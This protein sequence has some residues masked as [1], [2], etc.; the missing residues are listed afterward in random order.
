MYFLIGSKLR[1]HRRNAF[2]SLQPNGRKQKLNVNARSMTVRNLLSKTKPAARW[3]RT[4]LWALL[5]LGWALAGPPADA[6]PGPVTHRAARTRARPLPPDRTTA[7]P[8]R[9]ADAARLRELAAQREFQYVEAD[10]NPDAWGAFWARVRRWLGRHLGSPAGRA[11]W[12]Y[13]AYAAVLGALVF[14]VLKLLQVDITGTFGR[15]PRRGLAYDTAA[16]NIHEVDFAARI[17]E[18][19]AAGNLRLATRLGYLEVLKRLTDH[20][21]IKWQPDKT[22]HAYLAELAA[23]PLREAF[24]GATREFEYVWYGELPLSPALYEQARAGQRAATAPL[25]GNR[26]AAASPP[27]SATAQPA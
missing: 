9:R 5:L 20:G 23:G 7:L 6:Q 12:K 27:V 17:A 8:P 19:E 10:A 21:L 4:A 11:A 3:R 25:T 18:A 13:G 26:V 22:N 1:A 2:G 15:A 24:R 14:A 16:E